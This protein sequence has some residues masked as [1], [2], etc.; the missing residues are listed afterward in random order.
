MTTTTL[1]TLAEVRAAAARITPYVRRTPTLPLRPTY[2]T[3]RGELVVKLECF[4]HTGSFKPR[5]AFNMLLSVPPEQRARGV[6]AVSG[7]NHGLGVAFAAKTLGTRATLFLPSYASPGKQQKIRDLGAEIVLSDQ[8][9][10]C[11]DRAEA[12]VQETGAVYIH[13]FADP[14]VVAGQGTVGL[15]FMEDGGALDALVIAIGGGG[16]ISGTAIAAA[17]LRPSVRIYGVEPPGAAAMHRAREA[18]APV[19]LEKLESVAADSLG[20]PEVAPLT[21]EAVHRYVTDLVLVPDEAILAAQRWLWRELNVLAEPG[22]C[23][24]LAAYLTGLVPTEGRVGVLVCG[25]NAEV[26]LGA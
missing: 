5:G 18:G 25:G 21:L 26:G 19:R 17:A 2:D 22:G 3:P 10:E 4:Q 13:P 11:F 16:L 8:I 14:L 23:A 6:A 12:F 20:A 7:G 24:A 15:E 1:P 9:Q